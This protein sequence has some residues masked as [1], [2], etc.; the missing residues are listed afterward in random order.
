MEEGYQGTLPPLIKNNH[1]NTK[2]TLLKMPTRMPFPT[3]SQC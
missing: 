1:P 2:I 3:R